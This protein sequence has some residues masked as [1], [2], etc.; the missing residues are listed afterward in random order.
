MPL[1]QFETLRERLLRAGIAP[2]HVRRFLRELHDH[3]EDALRV[4]LTKCTDPR[5]ARNAGAPCV[6]A[7]LRLVFSASVVYRSITNVI[8]ME[9]ALIDGRIEIE[10]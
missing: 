2:R 5:A 7:F 3:Y 9:E 4:E 6:S 8:G 10:E 1:Q